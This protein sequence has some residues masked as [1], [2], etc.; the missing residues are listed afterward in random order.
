MN[1]DK[2]GDRVEELFRQI[3][4]SI[5]LALEAVAALLIAAG[6][7][8]AAYRALGSIGRATCGQTRSLAA[9]RGLAGDIWPQTS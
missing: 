5:A 7:S 3:A 6:A 9:F 4:G 2:C 1:L 8:V